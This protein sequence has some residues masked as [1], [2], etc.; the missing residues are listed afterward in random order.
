ME[1]QSSNYHLHPIK[2][3]EADID[4]LNHVN[5]I[6]YLRYVQEAAGSHWHTLVPEKL[7]AQ[8]I[9]VVRRH[10][11]DYLKPA[12]LGD[13]LTVK[14]WVDNFTGVTSDRHC[15]I[16]RGNEVLARSRT[17]WVSLDASTKRPKR[18]GEEIAS[19]FFGNKDEEM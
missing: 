15:E 3:V 8:V 18:I 2:V 7:S 19:L 14:T 16:L 17:L 6:V 1:T 9:W 10:E 4:D 12:F 13:E 11:I 5:N